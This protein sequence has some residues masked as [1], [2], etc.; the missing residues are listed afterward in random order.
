MKGQ[1]GKVTAWGVAHQCDLCSNPATFRWTRQDQVLGAACSLH[2]TEVLEL[3]RRK[4]GGKK[5]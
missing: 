5:P 1:R 2:R 4:Y 3:L